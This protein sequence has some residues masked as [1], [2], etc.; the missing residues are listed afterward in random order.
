[1]FPHCSIHKDTWT[2]PDG[3]MHNQMDY[4]LI[5][6]RWHSSI[7]DVRYFRGA[8]SD[9]DHYLSVARVRERLAVSKRPVNKMDMH[10][11]NLGKLNEGKVKEEYQVTMKIRF[12]ACKTLRIMGKLIRYGSY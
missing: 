4:V 10:T 9:T 5:D 6:R 1:V 2:S 3:K 8:D 12:S 7:L 11:F